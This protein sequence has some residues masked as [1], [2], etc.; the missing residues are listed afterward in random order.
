M[1]SKRDSGVGCCKAASSV[2]CGHNQRA[3]SGVVVLD[4]FIERLDRAC[5]IQKTKLAGLYPIQYLCNMAT[6]RTNNLARS[7]RRLESR[8]QRWLRD[9]QLK[10]DIHVHHE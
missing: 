10:S 3:S 9:E 4:G 7:W 1:R 2:Q 6:G 8:L 5:L